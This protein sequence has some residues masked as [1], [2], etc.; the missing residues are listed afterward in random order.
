M[1]GPGR[2]LTVVLAGCVAEA[3]T[4]APQ[5]YVA[6]EPSF[7]PPEGWP[8][9]MGQMTATLG[10]TTRAYTIYDF[11]IGAVDA[12]AQMSWAPDAD[13]KVTPGG[14]VS[15]LLNAHP[16]ADPKARSGVIYL[17]AEFSEI[18]KTSAITTKVTVQ[19]PQAGDLDGP[20]LWASRAELRLTGLSRDVGED[21]HGRV[22]GTVTGVLCPA[23]GKT[24][25]PG[26]ACEPFSAQF[27][28]ELRYSL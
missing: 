4:P 16:E 22:S 21:W 3:P 27:D 13:R 17:R 20:G 26:G 10:A 9:T 19:V 6:L 14:P 24:L 25:T 7:D 11:S 15:F 5:T 28:T 12:S 1:R 23:E 8:W 18:P 2:V